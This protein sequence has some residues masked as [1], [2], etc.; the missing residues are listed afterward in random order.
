ME[1]FIL[2]GEEIDVNYYL[3]YKG[4]SLVPKIHNISDNRIPK[5]ID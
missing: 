4:V 5:F 2:K 3:M 1:N